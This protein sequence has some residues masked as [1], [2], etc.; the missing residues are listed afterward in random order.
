MNATHSLTHTHTNKQTHAL[1]RKHTISSTHSL[2]QLPLR[3]R[4]GYVCSSSTLNRSLIKL[5]M[6]S[7]THLLTH[8]LTLTHTQTHALTH[9]HTHSPT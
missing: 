1:T 2:T 9:K 8:P 5:N 7:L 4:Y 3:P 6:N